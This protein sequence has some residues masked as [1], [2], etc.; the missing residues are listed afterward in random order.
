M[1]DNIDSLRAENERL[2][3]RL[4]VLESRIQLVVEATNDGLWDW[5]LTTDETFFSR[6]WKDILGYA[7][8]DLESNSGAFFELVHPDDRAKIQAVLT[9]HLER[10]VPY[11]VDFRMRAKNGSWR[12]ILARGQAT[13]DA[14][15]KPLRMAGVHTDVT[16]HRRREREQLRNEALIAIQRETINAL[17]VPILQIWRGILCLPILGDVDDARGAKITHELLE[18]VAES[19]IRFAIID[20]TGAEFHTETVQHLARMT[21]ALGLIGA[22]GVFCGISPKVA[23]T[24]VDAGVEFD[25]VSTYRDLGDALRACLLR[26][27]AREA[28]LSPGTTNEGARR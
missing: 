22:Q 24:L 10:R 16:E 4:D 14:Q 23:M 6:R 8:D 12:E 1:T 3:Q 27:R 17:G 13:W 5:D 28:G 21:R 19:A 11:V 18:R 26:L 15:G 2:R 9:A 20:L 25:E 7:E